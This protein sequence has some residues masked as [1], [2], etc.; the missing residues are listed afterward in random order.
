MLSPW[1]TNF[2][3]PSP[4]FSGDNWGVLFIHSFVF[5]TPRVE[6]FL[7]LSERTKVFTDCCRKCSWIVRGLRAGMPRGGGCGQ[8]CSPEEHG[9][10]G[11]SL[12]EQSFGSFTRLYPCF[13]TFF[14]IRGVLFHYHR[15]CVCVAFF[16]FTSKLTSPGTQPTRTQPTRP[17]GPGRSVCGPGAGGAVRAQSVAVSTFTETLS[18]G[19]TPLSQ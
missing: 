3:Y 17:Q 14:D 18:L 8:C 4:F 9:R 19:K 12:A 15:E 10:P 7:W 11:P 5:L 1:V 2:S 16:C 6:R 13:C